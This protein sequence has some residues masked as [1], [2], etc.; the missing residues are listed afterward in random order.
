V[1]KYISVLIKITRKIA[2]LKVK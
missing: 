1:K 2:A